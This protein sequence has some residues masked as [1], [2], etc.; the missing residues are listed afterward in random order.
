M[1]LLALAASR[2]F[3]GDPPWVSYQ[4]GNRELQQRNH[5]RALEHFSEA[6]AGQPLFPEA[7]AGI[8]R[9]HQAAGDVALAREYFLAALEYAPSLAVR[10][11]EH[12]I[13]LE[14]VDLLEF[15][16]RREDEAL[17]REQLLA[18]IDGDPVFNRRDAVPHQRDQMYELLLESGLDR[19]LVL[20]RL[21]YPQAAAGHWRYGA[22]LLEEND[23]DLRSRAVEHLLFAV[24][25]TAGRGIAAIIEESFQF[26]FTTMEQFFSVLPDYPHV[27][28]YVQEARLP[29]MLRQLARAL[30]GSGD[31]RGA[32]AARAI[33][34]NPFIQ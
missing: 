28:A 2:V 33:A 4:L 30:E 25:E 32:D 10:D 27:E 9:T 8:A 31:P 7:L 3:A 20:Y 34:R 23:E 13:R 14:L 6:L 22:A 19:V 12:R 16:H 18:I 1:V 29:L 24:V 26:Q 17:L 11:D 5:A 21:D 15:S